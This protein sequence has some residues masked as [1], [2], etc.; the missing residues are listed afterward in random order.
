MLSDDIFEVQTHRHAEEAN[1]YLKIGWKLIGVFQRV[2]G[3]DSAHAEYVV[4]WRRGTEPKYPPAPPA[5][6]W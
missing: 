5:D 3:N 4:G 1:E 6:R 2:S